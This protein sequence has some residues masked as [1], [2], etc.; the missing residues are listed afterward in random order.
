MAHPRP[1]PP[2][3]NAACRELFVDGYDAAGNRIYDKVS[4]QTC[5]QCRQKTLGKRTCCAGC[6]SLT[7][8]VH[9]ANML[10]RG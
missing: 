9:C 7:V 10:R 1:L 6:E 5:H 8:R 2:L 3:R 4:G